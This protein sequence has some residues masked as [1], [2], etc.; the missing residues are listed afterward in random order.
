MNL[1]LTPDLQAHRRGRFLASL[2]AIEPSSGAVLPVS[3]LVLLTG[4]QL[5]ASPELQ[6]ECAA[7]ARQPGCTLLVLPPYK[8]GTIL[9]TL[10][11][12]IEFSA[13]LVAALPGSVE[14]I[15]AGELMYRLQ[16]MDGSNATAAQ[17]GDLACHTRYW[18]AHSNS[19][20]IAATTLPLWSIS[21]LNHGDKVM[22]FLAD[23]YKHAGKAS[24]PVA[25]DEPFAD[26]LH[27]QDVTVMVC[28]Y[29]FDVATAASLMDR[30]HRYAVP[31]LNLASFDLPESVNR[32]QR[33]GLLDDQGLTEAGLAFLRA[34][35]YW[36]FAENLKGEA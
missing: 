22:A 36:S 29:G 9:P 35:K 19:G 13:H 1:Y 20:L 5:Q 3:G 31:L 25:K 12:A 16:G 6:A 34:S 27:P 26:A 11:W 23:I 21:L 8:E 17:P 33:G 18:K 14:S 2:L 10:D 30:L 28:C 24:V 4:E 15:V 7:W 32:L